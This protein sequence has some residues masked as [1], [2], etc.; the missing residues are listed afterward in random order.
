MNKKKTALIIA[1]IMSITAL[2]SCGQST[3]AETAAPETTTAAQTTEQT[4]TAAETT[5][6]ADAETE[7]PAM[8]S[9]RTDIPESE[10]DKYQEKI[11]A[12]NQRA[13]VFKN[14]RFMIMEVDFGIDPG[15][16]KAY[17][18]WFTENVTYYRAP[19]YEEFSVPDVRYELNG[20]GSD[21]NP[22]AT[23]C[24]DMIEGGYQFWPV[25]ADLN[26][27]YQPEYETITEMYI[28]D[29]KIYMNS[30]YNEAGT[31]NYYS[32]L[33]P[34]VEYTGGTLKYTAVIDAESLEFSESSSYIEKDGKT[35]WLFTDNYKYDEPVP[36]CINAIEGFFERGNVG[37]VV[38]V[39]A[40]SNPGTEKEMTKSVTIP[41]N[42]WVSFYTPDIENPAY[43][44]N[45]ECTQ[46]WDGD[47]D[48]MS[49]L[50]VYI[51]E[52]EE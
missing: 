20:I 18:N 13:E 14:H 28:Q 39:T 8:Q 11:F 36:S 30:V 25:P 50:T 19:A 5:T 3:P 16:Y 10:W 52:Y 26:E 45:Y 40:T 49:D 24:L 43:Y 41:A 46:A 44:T 35:E 37:A 32:I 12:A 9:D 27:W 38:T 1:G 31:E 29:G 4:T 15:E 21:W 2:S 34:Q 17:Y 47:W 51:K 23:Y 6:T 7:A 22:V 33:L 42:S 48:M